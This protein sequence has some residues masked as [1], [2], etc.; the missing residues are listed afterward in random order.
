MEYATLTLQQENKYYHKYDI[1]IP[2]T[3]RV[4]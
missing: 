1:C 3:Y 2:I 4:T